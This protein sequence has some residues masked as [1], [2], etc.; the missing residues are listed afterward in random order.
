MCK[1]LLDTQCINTTE[2][3]KLNQNIPIKQCCKNV[4]KL[5]MTI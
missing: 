2:Q 5:R 1:I 3:K 4:S